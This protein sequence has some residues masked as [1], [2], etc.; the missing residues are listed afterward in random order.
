MSLKFR[1]NM[2][3]LWWK[4]TCFGIAALLS[5]IYVTTNN[6]KTLQSFPR[7]CLPLVMDLYNE[8]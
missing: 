6:T 7:H 5:L 1:E 4:Q 2:G 3:Q 8:Y